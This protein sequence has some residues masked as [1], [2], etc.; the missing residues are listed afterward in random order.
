MA[1]DLGERTEDA[2][3]KRRQEARDEGN[4]AKSHD[5]SGALMLLF[6]TLT[7]WAFAMSMFVQGRSLL[8]EGLSDAMGLTIDQAGAWQALRSLGLAALR[9]ALPVLALMWLAA[10][11]SQFLQVGWLFVPK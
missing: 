10:F 7:L 11:A 2:T 1:E 8:G 6:A 9:L 5:L 3:P 4:V